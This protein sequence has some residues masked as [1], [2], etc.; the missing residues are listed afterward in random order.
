[1]H[2]LYAETARKAEI[3]VQRSLQIPQ[4]SSTVGVQDSRWKSE[5]QLVK[6]DR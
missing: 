2:A 5:G 1:M 6:S 3:A 4:L